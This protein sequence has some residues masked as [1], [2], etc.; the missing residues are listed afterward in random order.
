MNRINLLAASALLAAFPAQAEL[1]ALSDS[2]LSAATGEGL[3]FALEDFMLEAEDNASLQVTGIKDAKSDEILIDWTNL[4]IMGEG[5]QGGTVETTANIGSYNHPW[6]IST[7]RGGGSVIDGAPTND[8]YAAFGNDIAL[9]E[10]KSDDYDTAMQNSETFALYTYYDSISADGQTASQAIEV[11]RSL[12]QGIHNDLVGIYN[13]TAFATLENEIDQAYGTVDNNSSIAYQYNEIYKVGDVQTDGNGDVIVDEAT[14][15]LL[16]IRNFRQVEAEEASVAAY[17][18]YAFKDQYG[19][20]CTFG[21]E[22]QEGSIW[23]GDDVEWNCN[24][25]ATCEA[26]REAY[27]ATLEPMETTSDVRDLAQSDL[28]AGNAE[29]VSRQEQIYF[30]GRNYLEMVSDRDAFVNVCGAEQTISVCDSGTLAKKTNA[31]AS[32]DDVAFRLS[33]GE[34]RRAGLD[35]GSTFK[36]TLTDE[37]KPGGI[38]EDD[39]D[40]KLNGLFVDSSY[41][42][43]WSRRSDYNDDSSPFELNAEV[44][45]NLFVKNIAINTCS[46]CITDTEIANTTL[47]IDNL[48]VSLNLGYG[49]VQPL[50]FAANEDGNF[51]FTMDMPDPD[52]R[53][54]NPDELPAMEFYRNYYAN[55]PKSFLFVGDVNVNGNSIGST[56][57]D[58]FR[59]QYLKVTSIDL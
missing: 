19:G 53:Y 10:L 34:T 58:G 47:N 32:I 15:G 6:E 35:I 44:R 21:N 41:F 56:T 59:M 49:D 26:Q 28:D 33:N 12:L 4:Y 29:L 48:L 23:V 11:E 24:G 2:D 3:G 1:K 57:I 13:N 43:L 38:R 55:A 31:K 42:R 40:I 14:W 46:A 9:I 22:C 16:Q 17:D 39:L 51:V 36:I 52:N 25:N 8:E 50:K 5:S 45:L 30:A 37:N 54:A 18:A 20:G 7:I 27:N